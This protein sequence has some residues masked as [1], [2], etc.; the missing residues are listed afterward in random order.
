MKLSPNL[1]LRR[2]AEAL[3]F[4]KAAFGAEELHVVRN[5]AGEV[6]ANLKVGA[7]EFWISDES[8]RHGNVSPAKLGGTTVRL[9]L[10]VPDPAAVLD[11]AVA[12]GATLT[13]P[14]HS[15]H[16]W[17][18]GEIIDPYGYRWEIGKPPGDLASS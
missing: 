9:I 6:V 4:Y 8:P 18:L 2:G 1:F 11:R 5:E 17:V 15:A 3:E 13:V 12:V 14:L 16:G 7:S 10:T